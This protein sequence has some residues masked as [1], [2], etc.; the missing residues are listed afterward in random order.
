[1]HANKTRLDA[2][3]QIQRLFVDTKMMSQTDSEMAAL[4]VPLQNYNI[5]MAAMGQKG[6]SPEEFKYLS[7]AKKSDVIEYGKVANTFGDSPVDAPP[8]V[9]I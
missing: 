7:A 2:G 3:I 4:A 1:M 8:L 5:K 9:T 6:Y